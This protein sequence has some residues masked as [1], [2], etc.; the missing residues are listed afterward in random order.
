MEMKKGM[1]KKDQYDTEKRGERKKKVGGD[2]YGEG[3]RE[4]RREKGK[5]D[6]ETEEDGEA[7]G[8]R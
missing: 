7:E 2:K 6:G 8:R 3:D 1:K 5:E 4:E